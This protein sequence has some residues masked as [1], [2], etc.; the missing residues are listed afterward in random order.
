MVRNPAVGKFDNLAE[1]HVPDIPE[2]FVGPADT[3]GRQNDIVES[4]VWM[5][6]G[7]RF[8]DPH[9]DGGGSDPVPG[10]C[11]GQGVFVDN[12][13]ARRVDQ[14]GGRLHHAQFGSADQITG[15]IIERAADTDEVRRLQQLIQGDRADTTLRCV[16][17][18]DVRVAGNRLLHPKTLQHFHQACADTA[19]TDQSH[20]P[21]AQF[22][23]VVRR[24]L[25]PASMSCQLVLLRRPV[26]QRQH[27]AD[28]RFRHGVVADTALV[29]QQYIRVRTRRHVD[30][31]EADTKT[32]DREELRTLLQQG[33]RVMFVHGNNRIESGDLLRLDD[34]VTL[35]KAIGYAGIVEAAQSDLTEANLAVVAQQLG[36]QPQLKTVALLNDIDLVAVSLPYCE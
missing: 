4:E 1:C 13:A 12:A 6:V 23:T 22:E 8:V 9:V 30:M 31:V 21:V 5:I 2:Q 36:A 16:R 33:P 11:L 32:N 29:A 25:R 7:G 17:R 14:T 24:R 28:N 15:F 34:M 10:Q 35:E 18:V 20:D 19:K 3:V 27:P 26:C